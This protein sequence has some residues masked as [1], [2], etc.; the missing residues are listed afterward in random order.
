MSSGAKAKAESPHVTPSFCK[1]PGVLAPAQFADYADRPGAMGRVLG[2]RADAQMS[3]NLDRSIAAISSPSHPPCVL[4]VYFMEPKVGIEPTA[5]A[6][7]RRQNVV[8]LVRSPTNQFP[9]F[10]S[11]A[12]SDATNVL[13]WRTVMDTR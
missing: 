4:R 1:S 11:D 9:P 6:L 8:A 7:P 12:I 5:Y 2:I 3:P 13:H 10:S